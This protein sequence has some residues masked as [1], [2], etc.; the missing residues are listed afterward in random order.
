[1]YHQYRTSDFLKLF[2]PVIFRVLREFTEKPAGFTAFFECADIPISCSRYEYQPQ[3][4][5]LDLS[6][7]IPFVWLGS[8]YQQHGE[9]RCLQ[10]PWLRSL[11]SFTLVRLTVVRRWTWLLFKQHPLSECLALKSLKK[12]VDRFSATSNGT[13]DTFIL[14]SNKVPRMLLA[15]RSSVSGRRIL[16]IIKARIYTEHIQHIETWFF[17]SAS[18]N[19]NPE[20]GCLIA[21]LTLKLIARHDVY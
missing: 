18:W 6:K 2:G 19:V 3:D 10:H 15:S 17:L 20:S 9:G 14:A 1:M 21:G 5:H 13:I 8:G 7:V 4:L 12:S 16:V 11:L